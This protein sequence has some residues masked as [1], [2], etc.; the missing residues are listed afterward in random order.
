MTLF[1]TALL[2]LVLAGW[3]LTSQS[4]SSSSNSDESSKENTVMVIEN[5]S[6]DSILSNPQSFS[7]EENIISNTNFPNTVS[8]KI[9]EVDEAFDVMAL[10]TI[11]EPSP[12]SE[13]DGTQSDSSLN[14]EGSLESA[15][16]L[17]ASVNHGTLLSL[18]IVLLFHRMIRKKP[19]DSTT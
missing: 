17:S 19:D 7:I 12:P 18:L 4:G 6:E 13:N 14:D 11:I 15:M 1:L 3:G 10:N 2:T 9:I 5:S 16:P 8:Q